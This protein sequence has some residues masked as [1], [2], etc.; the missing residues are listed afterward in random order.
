M[1]LGCGRSPEPEVTRDR[2][3]TAAQSKPPPVDYGQSPTGESLIATYLAWHQADQLSDA[4]QRDKMM[5]LIYVNRDDVKAIFND[6]AERM[7]MMIDL[8]IELE[9][10][11]NADR[12]KRLL[13]DT[14]AAVDANHPTGE[15]LHEMDKRALDSKRAVF[16]KG[17]PVYIL[18]IR[19]KAPN[20]AQ[21]MGPF[22]FMN[23]RWV[24]VP[25]PGD[26]YEVAI[27]K[28][29]QADIEKQEEKLRRRIEQAKERAMGK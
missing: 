15:G 21:S 16:P 7:Q 19:W 6:Q 25:D 27:E 11:R 1:I 10:L 17:V 8:Q 24:Y 12:S 4:V 26:M 18:N 9:K 29:P 5:G 23:N 20:G 14:I 13:I 28:I 2:A 22:F 3:D